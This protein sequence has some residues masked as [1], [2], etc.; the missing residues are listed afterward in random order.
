[1]IIEQIKNIACECFGVSR[2][3]LDR[4][5]RKIEAVYVKI[6]LCN[7]LHSKGYTL[8]QIGDT[9]NMHHST[10]LHHLKTIDDRL[11]YDDKFRMGYEKF[12]EMV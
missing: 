5:S 7:L 4:N 3:L 12:N 6:A 10:V 11:K 9:L 1:M 8:M 2:D